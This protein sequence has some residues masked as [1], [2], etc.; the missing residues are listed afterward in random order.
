MGLLTESGEDRETGWISIQIVPSRLNV[1]AD[2]LR[3]RIR[4]SEID[5]GIR[6]GVSSADQEEI[7]RLKK[8]FSEFH[9]ANEPLRKASAFL[10][11]APDSATLPLYSE[12]LT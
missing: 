12:Q 5:A 4:R 10:A 2:T 8:K 3:K 6:P 9:R 7:R 1:W 11:A